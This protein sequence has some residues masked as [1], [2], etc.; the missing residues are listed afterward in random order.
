M[1][2][3]INA[4]SSN[5]ESEKRVRIFAGSIE[6]GIDT[7]RTLRALSSKIPKIYIKRYEQKPVLFDASREPVLWVTSD[8][9][10]ST[11]YVGSY[12]FREGKSRAEITG[13]K[14]GQSFYIGSQDFLRWPHT[15]EEIED[16]RLLRNSDTG[17]TVYGLRRLCRITFGDQYSDESEA[18]AAYGDRFETSVP[19][20][21]EFE[22]PS[23]FGCIHSD[24]VQAVEEGASWLEVAALSA[25]KYASEAVLVVAPAGLQLPQMVTQHRLCQNKRFVFVSLEEFTRD[26]RDKLKTNYYLEGQKSKDTLNWESFEE[27]MQQLWT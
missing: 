5:F 8:D 18:R 26:E 24:F 10:R 4:L 14:Q 3:K 23:D 27:L 13:M 22:H 2:K 20:H 16:V 19:N 21:K 12:H 15:A 7:R 1:Q 17:T 11:F 25:A 9:L 6:R